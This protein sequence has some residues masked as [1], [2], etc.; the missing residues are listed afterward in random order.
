MCTGIA[1]PVSELPTEFVERA[2]MKPRLYVR[3]EVSE[4]RF[5]WWQSP[6]VLPVQ[7]YGRLQGLPWGSKDRRG[8]LPYGGWITQDQLQGGLLAH[9]HPEPAIIPAKFG[10]EAGMW[11]GITTGIQG[12]VIRGPI[13]G[14]VVYMLTTDATNYYKNMTEQNARM[15]VL[16]SQVI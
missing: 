2:E 12:V 3:G 11:F 7:W 6:P 16:I 14:Y 5:F 9:L 8:V 13:R 1:L 15:P 4:A 10:H